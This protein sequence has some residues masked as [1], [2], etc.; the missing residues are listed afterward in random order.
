[1]RFKI[2][3]NIKILLINYLLHY[4][5]GILINLKNLISVKI[6]S[7]ISKIYVHL[8]FS[9]FIFFHCLLLILNIHNL[10]TQRCKLRNLTRNIHKLRTM[11]SFINRQMIIQHCRFQTI[12]HSKRKVPFFDHFIQTNHV[13]IVWATRGFRKSLKNFN[14]DWNLDSNFQRGGFINCVEWK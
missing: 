10:I 4:F 6:N 14:C 11:N 3:L 2:S 13:L 8:I 5:K 7:W 9:P 1:M 12:Y